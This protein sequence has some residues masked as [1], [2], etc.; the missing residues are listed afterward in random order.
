[1][2]NLTNSLL[3]ILGLIAT[4]IIYIKY[5]HYSQDIYDINL[6]NQYVDF[7]KYEF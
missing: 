2:K 7:L 1:M 3:I 5:H 4:F 6:L